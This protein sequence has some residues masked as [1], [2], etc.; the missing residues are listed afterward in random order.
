MG[1]NI[2][3]SRKLNCAQGVLYYA[4]DRDKG[5]LGVEMVP[6]MAQSREDGR[7]RFDNVAIE[8]PLFRDK[9]ETARIL[10]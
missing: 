3:Q 2:N 4:M 1:R 7:T 10:C 9:A 8:K 6:T 5:L